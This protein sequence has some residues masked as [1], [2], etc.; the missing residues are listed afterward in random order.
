[1]RI[2]RIILIFLIFFIIG[3]TMIRLDLHF[4]FFESHRFLLLNAAIKPSTVYSSL[5]NGSYLVSPGCYRIMILGDS[6][7]YGGECEDDSVFSNYLPRLI[8]ANTSIEKVETLDLSKPYNDTWTNFEEMTEFMDKFCPDLI[9]WFY[10][11][12]DVVR[13]RHLS[14]SKDSANASVQDTDKFKNQSPLVPVRDYLYSH[15]RLFGWIAGNMFLELRR[16]GIIFPGTDFHKQVVSSYENSLNWLE[17]KK[18]L[19]NAVDIC[20]MKQVELVAVTTADL[21]MLKHYSMLHEIEVNLEK[22]FAQ[23]Q[24][25]TINLANHFIDNKLDGDKYAISKYDGHPNSA[26]QAILTRHIFARLKSAGIFENFTQK[27]RSY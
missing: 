8:S 12:N 25:M 10:T 18:I 4:H 27:Q 2:R 3:E 1:M 14:V 26:A 7:I 13:T 24:I 19:Y 15:F 16:Y 22:L 6:W 11:H 9:L 20:K 23:K 17:Q 5:L 21:S